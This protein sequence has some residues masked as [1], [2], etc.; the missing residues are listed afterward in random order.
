LRERPVPIPLYTPQ[1]PYK[2][3]WDGMQAAKVT[4]R[5]QTACCHVTACHISV[6]H[7][8]GSAV[9]KYN[10]SETCVNSKLLPML[11]TIKQ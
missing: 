1:I 10:H 6:S 5:W 7:Y 2:L 8:G 11:L 3:A 4:G 9:M